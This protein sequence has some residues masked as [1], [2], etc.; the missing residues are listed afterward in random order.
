MPSAGPVVSFAV[1]AG[2]AT[3]IG[4]V[5]APTPRP[6]EAPDGAARGDVGCAP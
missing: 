6:D 2:L 5:A 1:G 4:G 3:P